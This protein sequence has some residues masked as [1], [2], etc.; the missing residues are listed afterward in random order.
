MGK[1]DCKATER[2]ETGCQKVNIKIIGMKKKTGGK[3][4]SE[5]IWSRDSTEFKTLEKGH[6]RE[7]KV[8]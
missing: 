2:T 1:N 7:A 6:N 4:A 5:G 3:I 8:L